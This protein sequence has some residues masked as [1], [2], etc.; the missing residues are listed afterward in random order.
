MAHRSEDIRNLALVGHGGSGKTALIDAL[1]YATE[2]V[3]RHGN[4]IEGTSIS[5][6]EPEEK[7]KRHTLTSHLFRFNWEDHRLNVIDTPGHPDFVADA[8]SAMEAVEAGFLCINA[9]SGVSFHAHQL[10]N[11]IGEI[12]IGRA[13]VVTH[14]DG[15]NADFDE[16]YAAIEELL[17][18]TIVP[19]TY[20]DGDGTKFTCVHDVMHGEGPRAKEF[21]ERLEERVAE[22]D[23]DI[24]AA[25]LETGELSDD[26]FHKYLPLAIAKEKV[27]PLF[28]VCPPKEL[29]LRK[30]ASFTVEYFPSPIGFGARAASV[31]GSGVPDQLIE[32][33]ADEPFLGRVF[34][35]VID[36]Y[37]GRMNWIRC[38]RGTLTPDCSFTKVSTGESM[39]VGGISIILATEQKATKEVVPGDLFCVAKLENLGLGDS[40]SDEAH[41]LEVVPTRY[42]KPTYSLAV[43]PASR[44]DEQKI[45]HGLEKLAS[46]DPTFIVERDKNTGELLAR[47]MSPLHLELM[48]HRLDRRFGV[49]TVQHTPSIPY[50][51]TV[52]SPADGH[53]RHKKQSGGRGQFAEVYLRIKPRERG[54]GFEYR[55]AVVGGSIPKQFISEIEKGIRKFLGSGT[56]AG[57]LVEDIEAEVYDGKFHDVDSD[58][59][60]FQLAGERAF[61][62]AF[63]KAHPILLEPIMEVEIQVPERFTG[64]VASNLASIRGRM[65]GM[66][67]VGGIQKIS[68]HVP[69]KEMQDYS[70]L[71]RSMTSGEGAFSMHESHFEPVPPNVQQQIIS[72]HKKEHELAH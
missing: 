18:D 45:T 58:Q 26:D 46:E 48:L 63:S 20:P 31:K 66:E 59:M 25:Y 8:I 44:G 35:T 7:E 21:K 6:T 49:K 62:D 29:G 72:E 41:Q 33:N 22:A 64:D 10:W 13:V 71:L 15:E 9:A 19:V 56:L 52:T 3:S 17:G 60:S 16:T 1:A 23:D 70:T 53:H 68:A 40:V 43:N 39:K 5:D 65:S 54:E 2:A 12:G 28:T 27:T 55:N 14:P 47:G 30:L 4:S 34:K 57:C 38:L 36:D 37:V 67:S 42:P 24:L 50:K 51:E 61:L 69:L 11:K 32:P